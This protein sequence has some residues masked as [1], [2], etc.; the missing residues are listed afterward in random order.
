M[1]AEFYCWNNSKSKRRTYLF[2]NF[3]AYT[4]HN[5][6]NLAVLKDKTFLELVALNPY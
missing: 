2:Y 5:V 1:G 4:Q 3:E 6:I